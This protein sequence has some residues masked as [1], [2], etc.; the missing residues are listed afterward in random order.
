[1]SKSGI[2]IVLL[3]I[4]LLSC[5]ENIVKD[6]GECYPGGIETATLIISFRTPD[7]IPVNPVVSLYEGALKDSILLA[8]YHVAEPYS[9]ISYDAL[10]YK[11]YT[12]TLEF[13]YEGRKYITVA[14]ACP[15]A[16]YDDISCEEPCWFVY[17]NVLD[18]KLRY[19]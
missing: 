6:C 12:A 11:D 19:H 9:Y 1:M 5:E 8:R 3:V 18:L 2:T 17:D 16:G 13:T 7:Y 15:Q 4:L 14:G 10:L